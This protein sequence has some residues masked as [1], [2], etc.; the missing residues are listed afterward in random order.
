MLGADRSASP[1]AGSVRE[2]PFAIELEARVRA[3]AERCADF[4]RHTVQPT[5][6]SEERRISSGSVASVLAYIGAHRS[7][8]KAETW[9]SRPI[10]TS[11]ASSAATNCAG[12]K[13]RSTSAEVAHRGARG[14]RSGNRKAG[15]FLEDLGRGQP[16]ADRAGRIDEF[17][18]RA[19][20]KWPRANPPVRPSVPR[21]SQGVPSRQAEGGADGCSLPPD[22]RMSAPEFLR[23]KFGADEPEP[24][25]EAMWRL[26]LDDPGLTRATT[27][28]RRTSGTSLTRAAI[29]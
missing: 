22:E 29:S 10:G 21:R 5:S 24:G 28:A 9:R 17:F 19:F 7:A 11:T 25:H 16:R 8:T 6:V 13:A 1:P 23:H 2:S 3:V 4:L 27:S 26:A 20:R 12:A 14:V 15:P 18:R